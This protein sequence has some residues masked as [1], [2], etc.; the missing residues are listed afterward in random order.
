MK[1]HECGGTVCVT[2]KD[3]AY[4]ES[5][6]SNVIV[7]GLEVRRCKKC[8][9][10]DV[11]IPRMKQLHRVIAM[12]LLGKKARFAP[13]EIRFLRKHLGWSQEDLARTFGV[14]SET[15]SRWE[16]G[17]ERMAPPADRLLRMVIVQGERVSTYSTSLLGQLDDERSEAMALSVKT[18]GSTWEPELAKRG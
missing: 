11:V 16:T 18:N 4:L 12:A 7:R 1:C 10:E 15:V 2:R 5:G 17:A 8:G 13:P 9:N 3:Y 6:L 14:R